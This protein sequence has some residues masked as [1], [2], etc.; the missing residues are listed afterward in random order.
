[1]VSELVEVI[2][3]STG[4]EL[5]LA[6]Q[7]PPAKQPAIVIGDCEASRQA[8]IDAT[9]IPL[10][11]FVV[12]TARHRVYLVGS[13]REYPSG[14]ANEST[15]WAV[16]D[17]LERFVGVRWYW[18]IKA[19]GRSIVKTDSLS[20]PPVHYTD[21]PVFQ[22]RDYWPGNISTRGL[23]GIVDEEKMRPPLVQ[24]RKGTS[25]PWTMRSCHSLP[26]SAERT[27]GSQ[28]LL[29]YMLKG[30]Q[31]VWDKNNPSWPGLKVAG[32][33]F[34]YRDAVF[35]SYLDHSVKTEHIHE[36]WRKHIRKGGSAWDRASHLMGLFVQQLAEQVA[37]RWPDKR[38]V[39]L[40]Y[41][42]YL[43]CPDLTFP[44][45]LEVEVALTTTDGMPGMTE[46]RKRQMNE[47]N[48][49]AWH[50]KAGG[51][52]TLWNY[53]HTVRTAGPAQFPYLIQEFHR[54]HRPLIAGSFVNGVGETKEWATLAPSAYVYMKVLWNPDVDVTAILDEW[55]RRQF[56]AAGDTTREL[57]Q[58]M[59]N[60]WEK[61]RW[62]VPLS[63]SRG[64]SGDGKIFSETWPPHV[65]RRMKELV[66]KA[67]D[68]LKND[69]R[70]RKRL[71][72]WLFSFDEFLEEAEVEWEK[73]GV[74]PRKKSGKRNLRGGEIKGGQATLFDSSR[75][76]LVGA[77]WISY[78]A[79]K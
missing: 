3:L 38:V 29:D 78:S 28:Q 1:M 65:V 6:E 71:D 26:V 22:F 19:D 57:L 11:G 68:Q 20:V 14:N 8:G 16:V 27:I 25:W 64:L 50:E 32:R 39:Y 56:G 55:C 37:Q 44:D 40:P 17:F 23:Q 5:K 73:A 52:I 46:R 45:N 47:R 24:L 49:R 36:S 10:E 33:P 58:M 77:S 72:Y 31:E 54:K 66:A 21:A 13:S 62:T 60:R 12:K 59:I 63:Q 76:C 75:D 70:A 48:I 30:C 34:V 61:T 41:W 9:Q 67:M 79:I 43:M 74:R 35:V 51:K 18:P 2:R 53:M 69:T 42:H 7:M 4:A 15:T